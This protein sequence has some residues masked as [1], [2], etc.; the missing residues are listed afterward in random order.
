MVVK[1]QLWNDARVK[2]EA[3]AL[4]EAGWSLTVLAFPEEGAPE[5]ETRDGME[6][7]RVPR[8]GR[9]R[10]S[11]RKALD[12]R[13]SRSGFWSRL[14]RHPLKT[15]L[16]DL[17][18]SLLYQRRLL[19]LALKT[20]A[21][22]FHAHDLDTLAV[23][24]LAARLRRARLVYDSHELWLHS[25]RHLAETGKLFRF[26]ERLAEKTLAP[27]ADAVIAVTPGRARKMKR[28]YPSVSPVVV[29]NYPPAV[30]GGVRDPEIRRALGAEEGDFLFLYQ[31]IL[32]RE[33]GLEQ[34]V[35]ASTMTEGSARVAVVGH[36]A[37]RGALF[38]LAE[39]PGGGKPWSSTPR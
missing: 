32:C 23:C 17:F 12:A 18:H 24:A 10:V 37:C 8:S 6:V 2:K 11:V 1:N 28:M 38:A 16:G 25:T 36:D 22:V 29:A 30:S 39:E 15:S 21:D 5:R 4:T 27:R 14:R 3:R 31:G 13:E 35:K 19:A 20:R 9:L 34:L 7:V 26:L 33:R